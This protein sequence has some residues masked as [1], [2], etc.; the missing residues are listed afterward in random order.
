MPLNFSAAHSSRITKKPQ[1]K[2]PLVKRSSTSSFTEFS[3]RKPIQRSKSTLD[4][5][6]EDDDFF[7]DRLEDIGLVKCLATDLALRDVAQTIQ[8]VLSH[9]FDAMP[10]NGGFNSTRIS[11][12][13]N[14]R[15]SLPPTV[16]IVHVHALI[17]SPTKTEREISELTKAGIIRR[18]VIPG[19]GTGGSSIGEGLV[20]SRDVEKLVRE[21]KE[22]DQELAGVYDILISLIWTNSIPDKFLG[23]LRTKPTSS[24]LPSSSFTAHEVTALMRAG[25]VTSS[26]NFNYSASAFSRP[27]AA[28]SEAVT[29]ISSISKAA[30]GS[31]AAVGGE[32]AIYGAGGRGG[33]RRSS[34][35][36]EKLSESESQP[37]FR[38]QEELQLSTPG[39]GPYLR[40]LTAAR[41]HLIS[42]VAKSR[43]RQI[44][45]YLLRERWDGGISADDPAAKAKKYRGE[46]FG[47]LPS[48]TR[49]W[50]QYYGLSFDW[51][52]AECLGAGLI[53]VFE[54]CSVGQ[55][56]RI[57]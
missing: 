6:D 4:A 8:Y 44:P 53:E 25:F 49:K 28:S 52:L 1:P 57:P 34:S 2:K 45:L 47:V 54:T 39:T 56:V 14:F 23:L 19:R 55:A 41:S 38:D 9:M 22:I 35:Q 7:G 43:F 46:F 16:T 36:F 11:E 3:R 17:P 29:S 31:L 42:L 12:I 51:V 40:L 5:P 50:K 27:D 33:I 32:G 48:R 18:M 26:S 13:L 30:S 37:S 10:E 24:S 21:M 20:L 15:R